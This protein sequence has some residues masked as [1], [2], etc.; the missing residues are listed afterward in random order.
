I[1]FLIDGP[2]PTSQLRAA[3]HLQQIHPDQSH[4]L[5][6]DRTVNQQIALFY[7]PETRHP[8]R[9][10]WREILAVDESNN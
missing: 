4:R 7:I 1:S 8:F 3:E 10:P 2:L 6:R 5:E 9:S